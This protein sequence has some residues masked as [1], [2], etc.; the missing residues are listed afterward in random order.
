[1]MTMLS[2]LSLLSLSLLYQLAVKALNKGLARSYSAF[3]MRITSVARANV[4]VQPGGRRSGR[5]FWERIW[6]HPYIAGLA[7]S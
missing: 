1:M 7:P 3:T 6:L 5:S 4:V 2:I